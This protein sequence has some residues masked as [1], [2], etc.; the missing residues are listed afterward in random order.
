MSYSKYHSRKV[1]QDGMKF[2]SLKELSR[3]NELKL[4]ERAGAI[5]DLK[6]QVKYELIPSHSE[7][8]RVIERAAHYIADFTYI[9]DGK[10]VVEDVKGFRPDDYILKRKLMLDRYGIRI[11]ET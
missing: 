2:D 9:E 10:L 3:W 6:R 5:K 8:G 11:R 4:L 7:N 1:E